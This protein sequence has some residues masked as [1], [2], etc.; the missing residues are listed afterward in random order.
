MRYR[1]GMMP[2]ALPAPRWLPDRAWPAY[3]FV[4]GRWPHPT[5]HPDGHGAQGPTVEGVPDPARWQE[6]EPFLWGVDLFNAGF[7]W[8][9]HEAWEGVWHAL[10][11]RG[12]A[13]DLLVALIR[14]AAAAIKLREPIP[15]AVVSH[16]AKAV[17]TC[18]AVSAALAGED[19]LWGLSV[20]GVR[21]FA[22]AVRDGRA[23][24]CSAPDARVE[25]VYPFVLWPGAALHPPAA[26]RE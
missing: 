14:L 5:R 12:P 1:Q 11:R 15:S 7:Y 20:R 26:W 10:G 19:R 13:A 18:D 24:R 17:V 2:L 22:A 9:A 8:E 25:V 3:A 4:P 23:G 21:A 6:V 16:A